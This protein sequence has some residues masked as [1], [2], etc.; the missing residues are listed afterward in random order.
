MKRALF[1]VLALCLLLSGCVRSES[2]TPAS[3]TPEAQGL[4][5]SSNTLLRNESVSTLVICAVSYNRQGASILTSLNVLA[6][7]EEGSITLMTIPKDTRVWVE[8]YDE[9]GFQY[10]EFDAISQ[11]YHA[12][13][14][15]GLA[16]QKTVEAVSTLLGGIRID[17]YALLNVVQ[18]ENLAGL[19]PDGIYVTVEDDISELGIH[20]GY[21]DIGPVLAQYASYSYLN[22]VGGIDYPGT[23]IYKLKR[24][25]QLIMT[26]M[27]IFSDQMETMEQEARIE[28]AQEIAAC[29]RTDLEA[30]EVIQWLAP[31]QELR[32][33]EKSILK[34]VESETDENT[35]WIADKSALKEWIIE[36]F[37]LSDEEAPEETSAP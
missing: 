17:G 19:A 35:Y 29:L 22:D 9:E 10:G 27:Q 37:Y 26:L 32:F 34:G 2:G 7:D 16:E 18:L 5:F 30:E 1:L 23:D 20:K 28:L 24:H 33:E 25:Q 13:E 6:R 36:R 12:A 3:P 21:Q 15:A 11:V 31:G 14:K 8:H 4:S